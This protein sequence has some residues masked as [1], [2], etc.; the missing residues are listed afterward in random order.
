[1]HARINELRIDFRFNRVVSVFFC[2][3]RRS[4]LG[5]KNMVY[6]RKI[7]VVENLICNLDTVEFLRFDLRFL[8]YL[9]LK[10]KNLG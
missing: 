6:L 1:M 5:S 2:I 4:A 7:K 8:K 3:L 10:I 9:C